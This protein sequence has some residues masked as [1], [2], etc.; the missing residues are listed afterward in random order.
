MFLSYGAVLACREPRPDGRWQVHRLPSGSAASR[1]LVRFAVGRRQ[2]VNR[3]M[4]NIRK[5]VVPVLALIVLAVG[6]SSPDG[7]AER[8]LTQL[9]RDYCLKLGEWQDARRAEGAKT[10]GSPAYQKVG[11]AAQGAFLAMQPL[12]DEILKGGR[13]LGEE[14]FWTIEGGDA[15]AEP[16]VN[17]YC[18]DAGFETLL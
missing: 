13:T 5:I 14:T 12:R 9:R 4:V 11:P 18:T 3:Q 17:Q 10:P 16:R 6:C 15:N 8:R 7:A 2:M 1:R